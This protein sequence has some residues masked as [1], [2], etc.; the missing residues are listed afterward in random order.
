[1]DNFCFLLFLWRLENAEAGLFFSSK[2][3]GTACGEPQGKCMS[4]EQG[5][6]ADVEKGG[7]TGSS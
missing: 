6:G 2:P 4:M 7:A 1:M 3:S 5:D